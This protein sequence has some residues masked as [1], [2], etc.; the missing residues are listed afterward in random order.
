MNRAWLVMGTAMRFASALGLHVR[1][2]DPTASLTKKELLVRIWWSLYSLERLLSVLTGRPSV[3]V[4][5]NCSVPIPIAVPEELLANNATEMHRLRSEISTTPASSPIT[6][7]S[8]ANMTPP[9]TMRA[10]RATAHSGSFF[11]A[12]IQLRIIT[13]SILTSLYSA[14]TM[15]RSLE[16]V[17]QDMVKLGQSLDQWARS[18]PPEFDFQNLS[19]QSHQRERTMLALYFRSAKI[20]LTRPCIGGLGHSSTDQVFLAPFARRMASICIESAKSVLDDLV[21][22]PDPR[23]LFEYGPWWCIVHHLMQALSVFLLALVF[24]SPSPQDIDVLGAYIRKAMRL[25]QTLDD[26]VASKAYSVALAAVGAVAIS[27]NIDISSLNPETMF[28]PLMQ[29][30]PLL[31]SAEFL[32][33][34]GAYPTL[35]VLNSVAQG[36]NLIDPLNLLHFS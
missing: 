35:S 33:T 22:Q 29:D 4:D 1:N 32:G 31:Y 17:H 13:Q 27:L 14:G 28:T 15:I 24:M 9:A 8:F 20:L 25:L 2:E 12:T 10:N 30:D 18:L 26:P 19:T 36:S 11:N 16:L 34:G 5:S 3:I 23:Y 6:N 7:L 21:D